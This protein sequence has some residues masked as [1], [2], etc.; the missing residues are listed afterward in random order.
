MTLTRRQL[1]EV[2]GA[3]ALILAFRPP[4]AL[5]R[6][7]GPVTFGLCA[8]VHQEVMHDAVE[9]MAAFVGA[10]SARQVDFVAQLGDFCQP[11]EENRR[12]LET[13]HAFD[14]PHYHV[15]GNHETDGGFG[16]DQ[17]KS[18]WGVDELVY[19]FEHGDVVPLDFVEK[20]LC[21]RYERDEFLQGSQRAEVCVGHRL[22]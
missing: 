8:D 11:R 20:L 2:G 1:L 3:S 16:A 9:R 13:F 4:P 14:G 5:R 22:S 19:A 10:M 21:V 6:G 7:P 17:V 12:F 18:F 15:R